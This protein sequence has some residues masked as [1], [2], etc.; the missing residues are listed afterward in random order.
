MVP[1]EGPRCLLKRIAPAEALESGYADD[2]Q[3]RR[4][5]RSEMEREIKRLRSKNRR[6]REVKA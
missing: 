3:E 4:D 5:T 1:K 2:R 6:L